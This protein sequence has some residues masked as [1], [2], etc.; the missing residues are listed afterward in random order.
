MCSGVNWG[1]LTKALKSL[2]THTH[3]HACT[4][5]HTRTS[6]NHHTITA[7]LHIKGP[8]LPSLAP[9]LTESVQRVELGPTQ[10]PAPSGWRAASLELSSTSSF[11][12]AWSVFWDQW[13]DKI[14]TLTRILPLGRML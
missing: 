12:Q 11:Y 5:A 4:H 13:L 2:H 1:Q 10:W 6:L 9:V 7:Y 8:A 3:T 14:L